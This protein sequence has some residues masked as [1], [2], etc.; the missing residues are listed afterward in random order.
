VCVCVIIK[1]ICVVIEKELD[2]GTASAISELFEL[3]NEY[4]NIIT[5][6]PKNNCIIYL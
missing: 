1:Q 4:L 2:E 3:K 5:F 6:L